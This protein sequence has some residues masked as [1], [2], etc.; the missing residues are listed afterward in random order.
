VTR[1]VLAELEGWR[2]P[3]GVRW[4]AAGEIESREE[5]FG[6]FGTALIVAAFGI[7]GV[8]LLEFK[9]FKSTVIVASV[10]P[11]GVMGGLFALWLTGYTLSFTAVVGFIALIG[12][13]VKNS[14]LLVDFTNQLRAQGHSV[15]RAVAEAGATRF[16]P[17]LLTSMTAIGGL[18]PLALEG[19]SLYSPLAVVI[20]GGLVSSTVLSRLVTPVI[21]HLMPP[22]VLPAPA[23]KV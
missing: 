21:Y 22:Q 18:I 13:E 3:P 16:F 15:E 7:L 20:I 8:L 19:S 1:A 5:S 4:S 17:V 11:L 6:G 14:V 10:M 23:Q 12:I 2:L 9:T